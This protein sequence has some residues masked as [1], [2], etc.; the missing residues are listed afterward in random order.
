MGTKKDVSWNESRK[1]CVSLQHSH[2]RATVRHDHTAVLSC[3][4][5]IVKTF[6]KHTTILSIFVHLFA[7]PKF[8]Q[9]DKEAGLNK[10]ASSAPIRWPAL[11]KLC[12]K[13]EKEKQSAV[14][15]KR[16][17]RSLCRCLFG[18]LSRPRWMFAGESTYLRADHLSGGR[19]ERVV[20]F[21]CLACVGI[22]FRA[23]WDHPLTSL[24]QSQHPPMKT[25]KK[26]QQWTIVA[27]CGTD[28]VVSG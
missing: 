17:T 7:G 24:R 20:A 15:P 9:S 6:C 11:R 13:E 21:G 14:W 1:R 26:Q 25:N 28:S 19:R 12:D 5:S 8:S 4:V 23:G 22:E 3:C 10:C 18:H 2:N 27:T 16:T